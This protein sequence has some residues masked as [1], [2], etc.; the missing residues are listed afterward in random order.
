MLIH[1]VKTFYFQ[2]LDLFWMNSETSAGFPVTTAD[3]SESTN[4]NV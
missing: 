3:L 1:Q 2:F 4:I